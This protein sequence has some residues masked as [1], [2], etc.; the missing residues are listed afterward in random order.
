MKTTDLRP[1]AIAL[2]AT[3]YSVGLF[4]FR[5]PQGAPPEV[6]LP[7]DEPAPPPR[8]V[9]ARAPRIRTRSS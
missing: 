4:A 8:S 1:Y 9:A 3:V 5:A 6:R 7:A 2:L